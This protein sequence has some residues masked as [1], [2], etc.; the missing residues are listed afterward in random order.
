MKPLADQLRPYLSLV[1]PMTDPPDPKRVNQCSNCNATGHNAR[2][3][4]T[5][6]GPE[7]MWHRALR[8]Q[9]PASL[10]KKPHVQDRPSTRL[11]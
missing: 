10:G 11:E 9:R 8:T 6:D 7:A 2:T 1:P 5:K 3:C 4:P